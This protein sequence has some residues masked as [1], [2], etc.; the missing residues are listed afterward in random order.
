MRVLVDDGVELEVD[1]WDGA[2]AAPFLLV[3]GLASNRRLWEGVAARLHELGHPVASVDLRGHGRSD[4]PDQGY[5]FSTMGADLMKVV[6]AAGFHRP[7]L[8]GQ[9]TGGNIVV[10]LAE[11]VPERVRG[12][13]GIDG[14]AL[15][16]A[17]QWPD[18]EECK[19][20]LT[21]PPLAGSLAESVEAR[22]RRAHPDWS[23]WGIEVSMANFEHL[24]D[25]TIRPW[26]TLERHLRILRA[27]WE[28]HPSVVIPKLEVDVLL[29]MADTGDEWA[30]HKR[31]LADELLAA[32]P[33]VR[34]EWISPGD[35]DLHVQYP[36][37]LADLLHGAYS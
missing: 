8:V 31:A 20:A 11:R 22:L 4:K 21:P 17:R 23:D 15:E 25:G 10:D 13:A 32:A 6:D 26:L 36:M 16:L 5:D 29:V 24:P 35:H 19:A 28:H 9:S 18:W 30:E 33:N 14:G 7:V 34:V 1:T 37:E 2:E 12:V 3:H 27:L